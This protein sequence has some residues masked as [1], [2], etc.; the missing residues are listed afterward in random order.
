MSV[1]GSGQ[2]PSPSLRLIRTFVL[3]LR[4]V[5]KWCLLPSRYVPVLCLGIVLMI[6]FKAWG[7]RHAPLFESGRKSYRARDFLEPWK[8]LV[9]PNSSGASTT[10][11]V[12]LVRLILHD[13]QDREAR[14]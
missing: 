12:F 2:R 10:P 9:L 11:A 8:P 14:K 3:S 6:V 5:S 13:W 4:I 7:S 1:E